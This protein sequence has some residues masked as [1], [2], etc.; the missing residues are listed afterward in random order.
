MNQEL[1]WLAKNVQEWALGECGFIGVLW[2][3]PVYGVGETK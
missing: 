2:A 1:R 3:D